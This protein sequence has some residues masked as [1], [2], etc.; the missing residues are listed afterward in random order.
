M[1]CHN[2]LAKKLG[3][4]LIRRSKHPTVD[5]HVANVIA[6]YGINVI[7]DVGANAGQFGL[8]LRQSGYQQEIHSF[9]P[10]SDVFA[11]LQSV[12]AEDD[13]WHAHAF[14]LGELATAR[15]IHVAQASEFS[16]LLQPNDQ[17]EN[18]FAQMK[19]VKKEAV[20]L[21]TVD[22]FLEQTFES[23]DDKRILLKMD[24]QGYDLKVF[25][26][27]IVSLAHISCLLSDRAYLC[28][29]SLLNL[30][31][32]HKPHRSKCGESESSQPSLGPD[33]QDSDDWPP[34]ADRYP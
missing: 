15:E 25:E 11:T 22:A 30:P 33:W 9:E 2:H 34:V 21:S 3:Y 8:R 4:D 5:T 27:A 29:S 13:C 16:S 26:G 28:G 31:N 6:L 7:L 20:Q 10:V 32:R 12:A 18:E 24:T 17:G 1:R 23:L 19:T 14:A